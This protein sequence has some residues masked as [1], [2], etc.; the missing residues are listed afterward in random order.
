MTRFSPSLKASVNDAVADSRA[1]KIINLIA[2]GA[3]C[4]GQNH[5]HQAVALVSRSVVYLFSCAFVLQGI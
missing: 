5:C 3:T 2:A 4:E 1:I